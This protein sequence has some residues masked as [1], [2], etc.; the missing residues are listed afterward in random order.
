MNSKS[1]SKIG[2]DF[3]VRRIF[4]ET[5]V[6][7]IRAMQA[8][9]P[10]FYNYY[11]YHNEWLDMAL[12]EV[13][14]GK[15]VAF[16]IYKPTLNLNSSPTL[17]LVGSLILKKGLYGNVVEM[18]N[19]FI[20]EDSRGKGYGTVLC[21]VAEKHCSK[22]GYSVIETEIATDKLETINFLLKRGY[23]VNA[24]KESVYEK[25]GLIVL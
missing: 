8:N 3:E 10:E 16:G 5:E 24:T 1:L 11:P 23:G 14:S 4:L 2:L 17:T 6:N 9:A 19:L 20:R 25:R 18:K 15:R 22:E 12:S 13:I 7:E 21:N